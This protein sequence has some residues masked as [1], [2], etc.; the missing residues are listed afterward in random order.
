MTHILKNENTL[1]AFLAFFSNLLDF[2]FFNFKTILFWVTIFAFL[3]FLVFSAF[4]LSL[5]KKL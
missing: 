4:G 3:L 5:E 2:T 1:N